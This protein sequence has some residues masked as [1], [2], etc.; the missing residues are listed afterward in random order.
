MAQSSPILLTEI[1]ASLEAWIMNSFY[2]LEM[3]WKG[4]EEGVM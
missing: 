4:G 1:D 3:N 2:Y